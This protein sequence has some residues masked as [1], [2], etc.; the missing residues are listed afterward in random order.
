MQFEKEKKYVHSC[1]CIP[2][3]SSHVIDPP[4]IIRTI[5]KEN[6]LIFRPCFYYCPKFCLFCK[7]IGQLEAIPDAD[8]FSTYQNFLNC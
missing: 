3:Y 1:L 6:N 7:K 8:D 2:F 5:H 4:K